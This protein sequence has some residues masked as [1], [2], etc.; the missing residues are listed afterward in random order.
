MVCF[1]CS[2]HVF[3]IQFCMNRLSFGNR[4]CFCV[5]SDNHESSVE[6]HIASEQN[7]YE[8]VCV[9]N[10]CTS[11]FIE[12]PGVAAILRMSVAVA[13]SQ[14]LRG[15]RRTWKF[16]LP[17]II[18]LRRVPGKLYCVC[19]CGIAQRDR[20]WASCPGKMFF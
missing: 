17:G 15:S 5:L 8:S 10:V 9:Y 7:R 20:A 13:T 12:L 19:V 3:S 2:Q 14:P 11:L 18:L 6:M 4:T 16:L 1:C